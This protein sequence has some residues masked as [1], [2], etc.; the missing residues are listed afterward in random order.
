MSKPLL[1]AL[2]FERLG[3]CES[4]TDALAGGRERVLPESDFL[5]ALLGWRRYTGTK[6]MALDAESSRS[7]ATSTELL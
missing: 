7:S 3:D 5:M 2:P 4:S 1:S 6:L